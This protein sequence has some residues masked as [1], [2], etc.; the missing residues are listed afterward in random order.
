MSLFLPVVMCDQIGDLVWDGLK[1]RPG[2]CGPPRF[3]S[4]PNSELRALLEEDY[5]G[6]MDCWLLPYLQLI[7]RAGFSRAGRPST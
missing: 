6:L 4:Y 5:N 7:I 3:R 2:L 1:R